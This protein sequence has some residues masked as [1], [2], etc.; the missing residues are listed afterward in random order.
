MSGHTAAP[1]LR[2]G[3]LAALL[4]VCALAAAA[5]AIALPSGMIRLAVLGALALPA[6]AL[7][8]DRPRLILYMFVFVIFSGIGIFFPFHIFRIL[9]LMLIAVM[10][11]GVAGGRRLFVHDRVFLVLAAAFMLAAIQS[12]A[13]AVDLH[14]AV[15]KVSVFARVLVVV[16]LIPQLVR[17]RRD[18]VALLLVIVCAV[19]VSALMPLA[20]PPPEQ[21][22]SRSLMWEEGVMRYEGYAGEANFF[23]Y[24]LV[25]MAPLMLFLFARFPRPRLARPVMLAA[26]CASIY[27]LALSFSRGGFVS[28]AAVMVML[29]VVERRNRAVMITGIA[30]AVAALIA[31]PAIY[32]D[33]ILSLLE[34]ARYL[35]ADYALLIRYETMKV[36]LL[37][38]AGNPL[39]GVG[40]DNFILQAGR[41]LPYVKDVH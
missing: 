22:A 38:G 6:A 4:A 17:E 41:Y 7:L 26:L 36:A 3:R 27:V 21:Y 10:V 25:F 19:L 34:A 40:A 23:A 20:V 14:A 15:A 18:F 11:L 28:M 16:L 8:I 1:P 24:H 5:A 13:F 29:L 32:W 39:F 2:K 35:S 9:S 12:I 37:L 31:A 30:A 33:R